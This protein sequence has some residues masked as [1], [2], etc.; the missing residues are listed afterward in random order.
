M[1]Q[2]EMYRKEY[3][4]FEYTGFDLYEENIDEYGNH[5]G[6]RVEYHF[7]IPGL[8]DFKPTW[9]FPIGSH[10]VEELKKNGTFMKLV[11]SLGMVELISYWKTCCPPEVHIYGYSLDEKQIEWWKDLY[12]LGL[13]EF[14]YTNKIDVDKTDFMTIV[15]KGEKCNLMDYP[16]QEPSGCLVPVG[17]G[18]DSVVSIEL[19]KKSNQNLKAYIINPRGATLNT[20][21]VAG[22]SDDL[23][24]AKRVLDKNMIELNKKGFLNGHTPYSAIVAFSSTIVAYLHGLK[25]ITLSN[26]DSANEST[27]KGSYVNHQYS[28]SFKFEKDFNSYEAEYIGS[29]TMYF[30][31]LRPLSEFQIAGY[32]AK[33]QPYHD[34]FRSCNVGSKEDV[35]CGHCAKCLF[36]YL[37]LSPFLEED[38]LVEIFGN[39]MVND[40]TMKDVLDELIGMVEEKPFE[41]VGSRDEVNTAICLTIARLQKDG[42]ELP[43]LFEYYMTTPMY[44]EYAHKECE[45]FDNFNQENLLPEKF[46]KLIYDEVIEGLK[47]RR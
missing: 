2:Y 12:F 8:V 16:A 41:C 35:W 34:I 5:L 23:L 18:K 39:D 6:L 25:Y 20:V 29:N 11:F 4:V 32:F 3:K 47:E 46:K 30:S 22:M 9:R 42:K 27:V 21:S 10:S 17:G 45:Y 24:V 28:K 43:K 14:F 36:V 26:E 13:G 31:L 38:R 1:N 7:N 19:L 44:M 15:S 33:Q 40:M 37:I